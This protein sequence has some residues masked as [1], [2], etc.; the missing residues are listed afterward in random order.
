MND[1][2]ICRFVVFSIYANAPTEGTVNTMKTIPK[3]TRVQGN[4]IKEIITI[5]N[6]MLSQRY[7]N[8]NKY[9]YQ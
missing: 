3:H 7:F 8:F 4:N 5:T 1:T 2:G 6:A 9:R